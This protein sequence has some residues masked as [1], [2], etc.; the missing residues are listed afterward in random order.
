MNYQKSF[1]KSKTIITKNFISKKHY[2]LLKKKK[3]NK[4]RKIALIIMKFF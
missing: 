1:L 2:I 4:S 3:L